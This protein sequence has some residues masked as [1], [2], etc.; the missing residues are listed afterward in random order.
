MGQKKNNM[1]TKLVV[2][3]PSDKKDQENELNSIDGWNMETVQNYMDTLMYDGY[4]AKEAYDTLVQWNK[5]ITKKDVA[6]TLFEVAYN[7][8]K[9][10]KE[11]Y[12]IASSLYN[13]LDDKEEM[14]YDNNDAFMRG[15]YRSWL[16]KNTKTM[17]KEASRL[18]KIIDTQKTLTNIS[19]KGSLP[20]YTPLIINSNVY[21]FEP[22]NHLGSIGIDDGLDIFNES[23]VSLHVPFLK[24][25]DNNG[26]SYIKLYESL[27]STDQ[28]EPI[29]YDAIYISD[30][31]SDKENAIYM[32][33]WVGVRK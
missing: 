23:I 22:T 8:K 11:A 33:L 4:T 13:I 16:I 28:L 20:E 25:N 27:T 15:G 9:R 6:Y 17:Q 31:E 21:E 3:Y 24:Y 18:K 2:L 30:E 19:K 14:I 29:N 1:P 12:K 7:D 10:K 26:N 5:N 32:T